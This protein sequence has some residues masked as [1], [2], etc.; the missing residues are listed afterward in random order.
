MRPRQSEFTR[1]AHVAPKHIDAGTPVCQ[2]A[3]RTLSE[4]DASSSPEFQDLG[5]AG[6]CGM[7]W[8]VINQREREQVAL[9]IGDILCGNGVGG[10]AGWVTWRHFGP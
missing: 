10:F 9:N 8:S 1:S 4:P 6:R 7:E 5:I 3:S 2:M